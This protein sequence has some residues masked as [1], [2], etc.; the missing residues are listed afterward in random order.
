LN[1]LLQA[2]RP[3]TDAGTAQL[4]SFRSGLIILAVVAAR[5]FLYYRHQPDLPVVVLSL[6]A[7]TLLYVLEPALSARLGWFPWLYF[8]LQ[9]AIL[10]ALSGRSPFLDVIQVLYIPLALRARRTFRHRVALGWLTLFAACLI[11]TVVAAIGWLEGLAFSL[12]VMAACA[13]VLSYDR[14]SD[15]MQTNREESRRLLA[16]LQQAH[17][18]LRD[19]AGR[20]E[21][22]AAARERNRLAHELHDSVSQTI[23][24]ITLTSQATRLLLER[25]P[26]RVPEQLDRLQAMTAGAL[27]QLRSLIAQ[28]QPPPKD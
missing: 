18:Q 23:F 4:N 10:L 20:T 21:E 16:E 15:R 13:F 9:T 27:S 28:L 7:F 26:A 12:L 11:V 14:L 19:Q 22:L 8:P 2:A 1:G 3:P 25:D 17:A 24:A 5:A 6:T